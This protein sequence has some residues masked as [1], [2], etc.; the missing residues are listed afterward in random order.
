ML[1]PSASAPPSLSNPS[2]GGRG[3]QE[4]LPLV[5]LSTAYLAQT[6]AESAATEGEHGAQQRPGQGP[7]AKMAQA[8]GH[9]SWRQGGMGAGGTGEASVFPPSLA[10]P[11]MTLSTCCPVPPHCCGVQCKRV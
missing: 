6:A 8:T 9:F 2:Q 10:T 7:D 11:R 1:Q 3:V 5:A 4:L